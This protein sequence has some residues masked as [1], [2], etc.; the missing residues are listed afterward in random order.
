MSDE[1]SSPG[2]PGDELLEGAWVFS[3]LLVAAGHAPSVELEDLIVAWELPAATRWS[4]AWGVGD[5]R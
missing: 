1:T 2:P 5:D 3:R 4:W